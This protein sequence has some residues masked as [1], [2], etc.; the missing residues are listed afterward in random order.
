[1]SFQYQARDVNQIDENASIKA[2]TFGAD[3]TSHKQRTVLGAISA[4]NV[5]L[6]PH[7]GAKK[8]KVFGAQKIRSKPMH[9]H[10]ERNLRPRAANNR[11]I[12]LP[13]S[14]LPIS[15]IIADMGTQ[16]DQ[17]MVMDHDIMMDDEVSLY[18]EEKMPPNVDDI[19]E[20][21]EENSQM[22][23]EYVMEIYEHMRS[24]ENKYAVNPN[25]M[26]QQHDINEKMRAILLDW[27]VEV[28][29]KF[30]LLQ[31]TLYLTATLI[32][33]FLAKTPVERTRLQL[34]GVTAMLIASKYEEIYAP[35]VRD[36]VYIT[37]N[38]YQTEEILEMER[39]MLL[40]LGFE[41]SNPLPLHF[42]RRGS[43]A[44]RA[45][46]TTHNTAKFLLE[47]SL[48]NYPMLKFKPSEL[49]A[50]ALYLSRQ[51]NNDGEW[52][53]TITHYS[54]YSAQEIFGCVEALKSLV[55]N[56]PQ[57]KQQAVRKKFS[58]TRIG[59]IT[60]IVDEYMHFQM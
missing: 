51:I 23:K 19:D 1:M 48:T 54:H 16:K 26:K 8:V 50:S 42:L 14:S 6:Q 38:A 33:R 53:P 31:E 3:K 52:D 11:A 12:T 17:D 15:S 7:G 29:I 32:D 56:S 25:Y 34:V 40:V 46:A 9:T 22:C 24:L 49:A 36:F 59:Q 47:L 5:G 55:K 4:N 2:K 57:A 28:H 58:S 27:L 13:K 35:E 30:K 43:K 20:G 60:K 10:H 45:D 39:Q 41:L 37:D 18:A 21:D 44:A